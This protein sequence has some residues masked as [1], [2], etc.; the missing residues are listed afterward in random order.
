VNLLSA[1]PSAV[2]VA[3]TVLLTIRI[4]ARCGPPY[5]EAVGWPRRATFVG[6]VGGVLAG[7]VMA[8]SNTFWINAIEAEVYALSSM[9]MVV[10][11]LLMIRWRDERHQPG[12]ASRGASN[13]VVVVVY[14]LGLSVGFHMGTFVV[15]LPLLLYFLADR[16]PSLIDPRFVLSAALLV[17]LSFVLGFSGRQ[18][19][20][21]LAIVLALL[22]LNGSALGWRHVASAVVWVAVAA[23]G[24]LLL[25]TTSIGVGPVLVG[26]AVL[27][28]GAFGA[29]RRRLVQG[30]LGFWVPLVL[31]LGLSIHAFLLIRAGLDPA[32]NE[33]DPS[34]WERFWLAVSRDQYKPGPPWERRA[35][36][37]IQ[38]DL[39]LWRYWRTQYPVGLEVLSAVPFVLGAMGAIVHAVRAR[40]SFLL[41]AFVVMATSV[42]LVWHLNF[43]VDEV[44]DRDYF[45]VG[46]FHFF[47]VWI[48]MGG[49][50]VLHLVGQ[51]VVG[52]RSRRRAIQGVAGLLLVLPVGQ[53]RAG[54][55]AHDRSEFW[56]ARDYAENL[57]APLE[58]DAILFT[59]GDNDT[60]PLWYLQ[61]V[62]GIRPDVRVANLSLLNTGWYLKEIRDHAPTVPMSWDD[63]TID[64]LRPYWDPDADRPVYLQELAVFEIL[65]ENRWRRPVYLAV[66]VPDLMGL[67]RSRMLRLEGLSYRILPGPVDESID[68]DRLG[69]IVAS[70]RW[71]GLL[72][73]AGRLDR[74]VHRDETS[75]RLAQNYARAYSELGRVYLTRARDVLHAGDST[76][77][78]AWATEAIPLLERAQALQGGRFSSALV[79]LGLLYHL[80]E[81][82]AR[83]DSL[84]TSLIQRVGE[85]GETVDRGYRRY[86]PELAMRRAEVRYDLGDLAGALADYGALLEIYPE[87]W[88]GWEGTIRTLRAMGRDAEAREALQ[89]WREVHPDHEGARSLTE[90]FDDE[91]APAA[92][93][94][95]R[96]P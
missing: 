2:A 4:L 44:R 67:D 76:Q 50:A 42:G 70:Y 1:L 55:F 82:G 86:L 84:Y 65:N 80:T 34:T 48:G 6:R 46:F 28:V 38:L 21:T 9:V 35:P 12:P 22:V 8:V 72:D 27:A 57:L 11:V 17:G 10:T 13:L 18:L 49:A 91:A 19:I 7:A 59:N 31:M 30:N 74:S 75:M 39:H 92:P 14:L 89:A 64:E 15:F 45:F 61:L 24:I 73:D 83:A 81:Q 95:G 51:A 94:E 43:R 66:T 58:E 40:R 78:T 85:L 63:P 60:F 41:L 29:G 20:A 77:V 23:V 62:E 33:A 56:V 69:R 36:F 16:T 90:S 68:A 37:G 93:L 53:L 88:I 32:I 25:R 71:R 5:G 96:N 54:W 87:E 26:M 79:D 3:A 52:E 47:A